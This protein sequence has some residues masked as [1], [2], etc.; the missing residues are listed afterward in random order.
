MFP[1]FRII[2][3]KIGGFD[4]NFFL[5]MEDA[6]LCK[7]VRNK[8]YNIHIT[9]E[10]KITHHLGKSTG[11]VLNAILPEIKKSHLYY[12]KKHNGSIRTLILKRYLLIKFG[13]KK[14]LFGLS[15]NSSGIV[16]SSAVIK[17]IRKFK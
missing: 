15:K 14:I 16:L 4:E 3:R 1:Y 2:Y 6:D 17:T 5:Y 7:R 13:F 10:S 9:S 8:G 12:Y 11:K